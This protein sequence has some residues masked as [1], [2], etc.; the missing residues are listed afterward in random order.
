[1]AKG[2]KAK[3]AKRPARK[4]KAPIRA[5]ELPF[6]DPRWRPVREEFKLISQYSGHP[7]L[8]LFD[9]NGALANDRVQSMRRHIESGKPERLLDFWID[10]KLQ[11]W[12]DEGLLVIPR[13]PDPRGFVKP[14]RGFA[15]FLWHP[16]V[17]KVWPAL[18]QA[19][20]EM[21][22]PRGRPGTKPRD[23]WY[24]LI[25][26]WL[27][28]VAYDDPRRLRNVARLVPKAAAFLQTEIGWSPKESKE[29]RKKIVELLLLV[30]R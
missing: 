19:D 30:P 29:L 21:V 7:N 27:L 25:A 2:K 4:R 8:A 24:T 16:H 15:F 9:L 17:E 3:K 18:R 6:D 23:D 14:V 20:D 10:H 22:P 5:V 13:L 1:M 26:Q 12:S 28:A 11:L